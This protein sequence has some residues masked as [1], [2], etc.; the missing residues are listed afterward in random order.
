MVDKLGEYDRVAEL[1]KAKEILGE[2]VVKRILRD[3]LNVAVE[4]AM[5]EDLEEAGGDSGCCPICG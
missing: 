3:R 1:E 5:V 2:A 4:R